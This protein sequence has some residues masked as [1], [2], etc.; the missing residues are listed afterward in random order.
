MA[1]PPISESDDDETFTVSSPTEDST[2][3]EAGDDA[4]AVRQAAAL[5]RA[6]AA[7][8]EAADREAAEAAYKTREPKTG[9]P[10]A[11]D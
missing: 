1:Q 8:T 10:D 5:R 7:A 9:A 11:Q 2:D 4:D 3:T 6:R